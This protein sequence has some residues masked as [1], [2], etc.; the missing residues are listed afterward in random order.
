MRAPA[1]PLL[2]GEKVEDDVE[3]GADDKDGQEVPGE[4]DVCHGVGGGEEGGV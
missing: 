3:G 4:V 1:A 2:P